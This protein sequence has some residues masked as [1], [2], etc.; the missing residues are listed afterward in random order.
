MSPCESCHAGCCR[1]FAVPVT[2]ADLLRIERDLGYRLEETL[3]R[4]KD[5]NGVIARDRAPQ[6]RFSDDPQTPYVIGL[7]HEQ[8][9]F[10][11]GT[12]RCQFLIEGTPDARHPLGIARCGIYGSRPAACRT[13]PARLNPTGELAILDDVPRRGRDGDHP[14]YE[15]CPRPWEPADVDPLEAVQD[16]IVTRFEAAFF[17]QLAELW[18]RNPRVWEVFPEFLRRAY[19]GRVQSTASDVRVGPRQAA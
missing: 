6:F 8:S 12:T 10:F 7:Q 19:A 3:C 9:S 13:F 5:P 1:S 4:W 14:A 17:T 11:S 18:N 16:L 2:G 15:L